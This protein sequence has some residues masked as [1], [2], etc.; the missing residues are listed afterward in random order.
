MFVYRITNLIN[1]K[2]YIGQANNKLGPRHRI[3]QHANQNDQ[4]GRDIKELGWQ[5]FYCE[6]IAEAT[7]PEHLDHI[8]RFS[9]EKYNTRHPNGYNLA[10]GH[11]PD[12][13]NN[14]DEDLSGMGRKGWGKHMQRKW[15]RILR[16][17]EALHPLMSEQEWLELANSLMNF[18][19]NFRRWEPENTDDARDMSRRLT[20]M[21][22]SLLHERVNR[23][24]IS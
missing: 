23:L 18:E 7:S 4:L 2:T 16:Q 13:G 12:K 10:R 19:K 9:I 15:S 3:K 5:C 1:D 17:S 24:A 20:I 21:A 8:E 22:Q 14:L 11:E 6:L